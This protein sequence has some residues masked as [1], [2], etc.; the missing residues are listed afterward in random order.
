MAGAAPG[1]LLPDVGFVVSFVGADG[2][3]LRGRLDVLWS[4]RFEHVLP[5]R[6]FGSYRAQRSFQGASWFATMGDTSCSSPGSSV[7]C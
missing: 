6:E 1:M 2:E 7:T 4:A 3:E 5:V